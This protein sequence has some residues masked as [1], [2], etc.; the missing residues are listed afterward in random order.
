[1]SRNN[2]FGGFVLKAARKELSRPWK[3][4]PFIMASA[5]PAAG[6]CKVRDKWI[7]IKVERSSFIKLKFDDLHN[8]I[9]GPPLKTCRTLK[10]NGHGPLIYTP[11]T[12]VT[13]PV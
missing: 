5:D 11:K 12:S 7:I 3:P 10:I 6:V 1:V 2:A 4:N 8:F 9:K 13:P